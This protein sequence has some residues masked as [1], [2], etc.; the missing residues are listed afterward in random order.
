MH[1]LPGQNLLVP[2]LCRIFNTAV[3]ECFD[4][5]AAEVGS[6]E[7]QQKPNP[8]PAAVSPAASA[9]PTLP[10]PMMPMFVTRRSGTGSPY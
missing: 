3:S 7:R 10:V 4:H 9:L 8:S 5:R 2:L 6:Y 1:D